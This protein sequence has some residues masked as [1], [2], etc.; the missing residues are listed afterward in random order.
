MADY[1]DKLTFSGEVNVLKAILISSTGKTLDI[2]ASIGDISIFEDLFS[3]TMTGFVL[4]ED[5]MDLI[6]TLP[7]IGQEQLIIDIQ[8]PTLKD[9]IQKTFYVYKLQSRN[10]KKRSQTYLLNFC[11]RELIYSANSK[12]SK[13][14]TGNIGDTVEKIFRD[15]RYISSDSSLNLE[16]TK[17]T[18]DF[19]APFWSPLETINWL[20]G[21]A[22]NGRGVPNYLF[23]EDGKSFNFV[24]VDSLIRKEPIREYIFADVDANT[25]YGVHGSDDA[26]YGIV[27]SMDNGVTF[28]YLRNLSAGMYS[29]KLYTFDNTNKSIA[30]NS[31]DYIDDFDKSSHLEKMPLKTNDLFRK[32]LANLYFIHKN[33]YLTGTYKTQ[34]YKDSFLQ[35]NSLLE[36]LS[37]FK[38]S[39][40]VHGRTDIKVGQTITFTVNELRQILGD[41]MDK[42]SASSE[43]FS[44]KYL[45]T[46]IRHQI[47]SGKHSMYME[48]VSDSFVKNLITKK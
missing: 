3:N 43:Y 10:I 26:K 8:T 30:S 25:A 40:K 44:G 23:Y 37:A 39:I 9:R 48:I 5:A 20:T 21:K 32:K 11:S 7:L 42:P 34:G 36:Q 17:N 31:F 46:A 15:P 6:N 13:A 14:F 12:V 2:S 29:S 27:E 35:R 19:I 22:I 47:I 18:Y 16:L 33:N 38:I 45:I 1:S 41:E 4:I 24:S 28:D